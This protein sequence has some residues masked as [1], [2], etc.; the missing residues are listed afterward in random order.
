MFHFFFQ[1]N[2]SAEYLI[3][4]YLSDPMRHEPRNVGI[5]LVLGDASAARFI[6]EEGDTGEIDGRAVRWMAHPSIYRKWVKYW[7]EQLQKGGADLVDR[8]AQTNGDNYNVIKGGYVTDYGQD[9]ASVICESLFG[10][11]ALPRE[12]L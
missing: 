6:G 7:R 5:I 4:Q 12:R 2:L 8:L 10:Q 11:L 1:Q 3:A 9:P